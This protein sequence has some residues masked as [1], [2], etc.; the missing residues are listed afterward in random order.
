[1]GG[2][3]QQ[4]VHAQWVHC[5]YMRCAVSVH[6]MYVFGCC[7]YVCVVVGLS[8][9]TFGILPSPA[10]IAHKPENTVDTG[11]TADTENTGNTTDTGNKLEALQTR[12]VWAPP[13]RWAARGEPHVQSP[14]CR[15]NSTTIRGSNRWHC[16]IFIPDDLFHP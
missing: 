10:S 8:K 11:N 16:F 13:F 1:M 3:G 5:V 7:V 12:L 4:C 9:W 2:R 15:P 14:P 6:C